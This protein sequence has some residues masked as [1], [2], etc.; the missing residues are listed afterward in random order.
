MWC[1]PQRLV[2]H[3][4][5]RTRRSWRMNCHSYCHASKCSLLTLCVTF[6]FSTKLPRRVVNL[7]GWI[8]YWHNMLNNIR[9]GNTCIPTTLPALPKSS[10]G[11]LDLK[12]CFKT[13]HFACL[14]ILGSWSADAV[15]FNRSSWP[16]TCTQTMQIYANSFWVILIKVKWSPLWSSIHCP[17][18]GIWTKRYSHKTIPLT[19]GCAQSPCKNSWLLKVSPC[20]LVQWPRQCWQMSP[21][22]LC[23]H[24][25]WRRAWGW[26]QRLW[27]PCSNVSIKLKLQ[28]LKA[29]E[30]QSIRHCI[31]EL[32]QLCPLNLYHII[33]MVLT[34]C[35]FPFG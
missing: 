8:G 22:C 4:A 31:L 7:K 12:T 34:M 30:Q 28:K 19:S 21:S 16:A 20:Q 23:Q 35:S 9:Q 3:P 17:L 2:R 18:V 6:I 25:V 24:R 11:F 26:N 14:S 10:N 5:T 32:L 27:G 33:L 13:R 15:F 1:H 29:P